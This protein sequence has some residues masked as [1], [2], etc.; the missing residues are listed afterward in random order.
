VYPEPN[1]KFG[2]SRSSVIANFGSPD[3]QSSTG[4]GYAN[5]SNAAPMLVFLFD[6]SDKLTG[7]SLLIKSAYSSTL[8]DF[9]L[10]RY[11]VIGESGGTFV[12][13]NGLDKSTT[14]MSIGLSL[15]DIF[16]WQVIYI[17]YTSS[18]SFNNNSDRT[19]EFNELFKQ[20]H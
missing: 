4:I 9:L 7:Y 17:P 18:K 10:E 20:L 15:Y 8:A 13:I 12:F 5:Y 2:D 16:Y 11:M 3:T 19:S 1:V 6:S 14:T